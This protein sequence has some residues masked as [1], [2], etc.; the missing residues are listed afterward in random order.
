MGGRINIQLA[1]LKVASLTDWI[2][3]IS[4]HQVNIGSILLHRNFKTLYNRV[5][6]EYFDQRGMK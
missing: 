5:L 6:G 3:S 4:N 2:F 1:C